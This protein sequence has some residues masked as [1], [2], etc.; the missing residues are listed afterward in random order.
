[1]IAADATGNKVRFDASGV[2]FLEM[3]SPNGFSPKHRIIAIGQ[4]QFGIAGFLVSPAS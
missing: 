4:G 1:M 2:K 3:E